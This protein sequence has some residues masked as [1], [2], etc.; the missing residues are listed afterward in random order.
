MNS[1]KIKY[2]YYYWILDFLFH[3]II[4]Y[5]NF[6]TKI[7]LVSFGIILYNILLKMATFYLSLKVI[8]PFLLDKKKPVLLSIIIFLSIFSIANLGV[9]IDKTLMPITEA[10]I[11]ATPFWS[12]NVMVR[13]WYLMIMIP[14]AFV[15]WYAEKTI[16]QEKKQQEIVKQTSEL[17]K[18]IVR[19]ELSSIKNQINPA[20][21]FNTLN[22]FYFQA[23]THSSNLSRAI[24]LLSEMM[25]YTLHDN[26]QVE[27]VPLASELKHIQNY[28]EIQQLRYDN[29]LQVILTVLG[30]ISDKQI[31][32]LILI[33][34]VENAFKHGELNTPLKPLK[35]T[36]NVE[37]DE[38]Q[39]MIHN[40]KRQGPIEIQSGKIG[41]E[42]TKKRLQLGYAGCHQLAIIDDPYF[43]Q[44]NL[45]I[46]M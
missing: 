1:I 18:I 38:L 40:Y 33:T 43:Y 34:F 41:L 20:F 10:N 7:N 27:K 4:H 31:M 30:D 5:S 39:F 11:Q 6:D 21:L 15:Y 19:S 46:E 14:T 42:N 36:V 8:F 3:S 37:K 16:I 29:R 9:W 17:E 44:V 13:S 35:I 32:P 2:H 28:I 25:S 45:F 26:Y 24:T 22:F 23:K 12:I